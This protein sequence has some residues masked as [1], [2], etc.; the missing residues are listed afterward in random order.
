MK[1]SEVPLKI[2]NISKT[3]KTGFLNLK[4]VKAV[5]DLSFTMKKGEIFGLLGPNGAGKTTTLKILT[6]LIFPDQGQIEV[7]GYPANSVKARSHIGFLPE[8]PYFYEYLTAREFLN[9]CADI[10]NLP[11]KEKLEKIDYLLNKLSIAEAADRPLRKF[12][13]GMLQR[14]GLAQALIN[15]P[16]LIILDEPLSGLDPI[17]RRD[18][19]EI[20]TNLRKQ[21]K[22]VLFSSHILSDVEEICDR[23]AII[24]RGKLQEIG[25]IA[26]LLSKGVKETEIEIEATKAQLSQLQ[27]K[28]KIFTNNTTLSGYRI[29]LPPNIPLQKFI[30]DLVAATITIKSIKPHKES[31]ENLFLNFNMSTDQNSPT[32]LQNNKQNS[33]TG[34]QKNKD[35]EIE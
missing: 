28:W 6:G 22:T 31:L 12:S 10:F 19:R 24:A 14:T 21:G 25:T 33:P 4:R 26:K 34:L 23:A 15:D 18:F 29:N 16:D 3:F 11:K 8:N 7:F 17:G 32:G 27:K 30:K 35:K 13:K 20:I 1:H 2:I 9:M 5:C